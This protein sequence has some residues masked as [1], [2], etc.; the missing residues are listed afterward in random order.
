MR[1][2]AVT[3]MYPTDERPA[4]GTFVADQVRS[5]RA[6]GVEADVLFVDRPGEG[7]GAYRSLARRVRQAVSSSSPDLV[8]VMYGGVMADTVTRVVAD[9]PVLV[10]F[11][12][13]DLEGNATSGPLGALSAR[14][15]VLASKRAARRADGVVVVS[16]NL[17]EALPESLDY[18]RVWI[19]PNGVDLSRFAP[20]DRDDCRRALGWVNRRKH[21]LF[22]AS[23]VRAEKG[24][25]LAEAAVRRLAEDGLDV[26]LRS[27][28]GVPHDEVPTWFNAADAVVLTSV[29]EGSPNVVK[30]A[31]ACNVPV[32]SLDVGDVRERLDGIEGC[33]LADATPD[34]VA[35]KLARVLERGGRIE[36]RESVTALSLERIAAR[37]R[38]IYELLT[39]DRVPVRGSGS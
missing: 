17:Y 24:Y 33:F 27:L 8:H 20:R 14:Y 12:G 28:D 23:P 38:E 22:P 19:I 26:E 6:L 36:G 18:S 16:R 29:R 10:T 9:R 13:A 37:V 5:V 34:D 31:L 21:V 25:P 35:A 32:V 2:L 15:G 39:S 7:R 30:E 11:C 1:V 4:S 3:N